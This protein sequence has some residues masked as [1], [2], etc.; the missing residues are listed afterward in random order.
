MV[1]APYGR[2]GIY[3]MQELCRRIGIEATEDGI[4]DLITMLGALPQEHPLRRVGEAADFHHASAIADVLLHPHDRAYSVAQ[5][6]EFLEVAGLTFGRWVRQGHYSPHCGF[7]ARVAGSTRLAQLPAPEQ[8]AAVELLRGSLVRHS[9]VVYHDDVSDGAHRLEFEGDACLDYVPLR[10]ADTICVQE[11]VP[12]GAVAVLI[13]RGHSCPDIVL[14]LTEREKRW[15][16]A[17]DGQR[18]IGEI[19]VAERDRPSARAFFER[20]WW[21]DQVVFDASRRTS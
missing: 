6:F 20:L 8:F 3:M 5:L 17:I 10:V 9:L 18:T 4:R 11:R 16:D 13:N 21:Y 1:Y 7:V 2:A 15:F 12:A 14:P 19:A